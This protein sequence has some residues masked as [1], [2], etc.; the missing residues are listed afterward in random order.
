MDES[1]RDP[2]LIAGCAVSGASFVEADPWAS[3]ALL[4][5]DMLQVDSSSCVECEMG[6]SDM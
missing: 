6:V 1:S 3:F 2:Q 4:D 5:L